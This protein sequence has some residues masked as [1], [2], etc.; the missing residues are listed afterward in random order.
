MCCQIP[1][2]PRA[3]PRPRR[4][5]RC[6]R[7]LWRPSARS[8]SG[9]SRLHARL[10]RQNGAASG[11]DLVKVSA[12]PWCILTLTLPT[13]PQC[14]LPR[15]TTTRWPAPVVPGHHNLLQH[16]LPDMECFCFLG[17]SLL[18]L[19]NEIFRGQFC[20]WTRSVTWVFSLAI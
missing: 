18:F 15:L 7:C 3:A 12:R 8:T 4:W 9:P 20:S 14:A 5:S 19:L 6:R 16:T 10:P 2:Y 17:S 1:G 13:P 11:S